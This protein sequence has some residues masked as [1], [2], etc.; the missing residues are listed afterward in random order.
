MFI[1]DIDNR[2]TWIQ[3]SDHYL[4]T[5]AD[6]RIRKS[7]CVVYRLGGECEV[8]LLHAQMTDANTPVSLT[9]AAE[10]YEE[11]KWVLLIHGQDP[12]G[13]SR[14]AP[15]HHQATRPWLCFPSL[16]N[17]APARSDSSGCGTGR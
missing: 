12:L 1:Y 15:V 17:M 11:C 8:G 6:D 5:Y 4:R 10:R 14:F 13:L 2:L 3:R 7:I 16:S 9:L